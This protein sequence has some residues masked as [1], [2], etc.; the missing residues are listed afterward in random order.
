MNKYLVMSLLL[1]TGTLCADDV[2]K[3]STSDLPRASNLATKG[4]ELALLNQLISVT[5][6]NLDAQKQLRTDLQD[7][8]Q[9]K[10]QYMQ[11][12]D[13]KQLTIRLVTKAHQLLQKIQDQHLVQA[14]DQEFIS[15]LT[16][17]SNIAAKWNNPS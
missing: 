2:I 9:I 16:F 1:C 15:E 6:Q 13:D 5:Q 8:L 10:Q 11:K 12:T 4:D 17:F 3:P 7:Y 14:F